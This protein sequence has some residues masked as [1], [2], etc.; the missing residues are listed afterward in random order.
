MRILKKIINW[1]FVP[2][3]LIK[4]EDYLVWG[5][6]IY[7][8]VFSLTTKTESPQIPFCS[9]I[10]S[11]PLFPELDITVDWGWFFTTFSGPAFRNMRFTNLT[12]DCSQC[13]RGISLWQTPPTCF[14]IIHFY[15]VLDSTQQFSILL[16]LLLLVVMMVGF[17]CCYCV[18]VAVVVWFALLFRVFFQIYNDI[19]LNFTWT[20]LHSFYSESM[21]AI[22]P[23]VIYL[24]SFLKGVMIQIWWA[25]LILNIL[26]SSN[27]ILFN[28]NCH[29]TL[30]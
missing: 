7:L 10:S 30:G 27:S 5:K 26:F 22:L 9:L 21:Q 4:F 24:I 13:T 19:F 23:T 2:F 16:L 1:L 28:I 8:I 15:Q 3:L 11:L 14:Y 12:P 20:L 17:C 6:G 18:V 25:S 29:F